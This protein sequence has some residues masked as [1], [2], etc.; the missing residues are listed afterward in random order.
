MAIIV[1][2]PGMLSTVQDLGRVGHR[3]LGINPGGVMDRTATRILNTLVGNPESAAVIEM[4]FPAATI[5]FDADTVFAVGGADFAPM[6]DDAP[7]ETWQ[8]KLASEGTVLSFSKKRFGERTYLAVKGG[9][10]TEPWLGSRS[11]NTVAGAGGF[12]GRAL[13]SGDRL[14]CLSSRSLVRL[15]AGVSIRPGYSRSPV[16]RVVAGPEFEFVTALS[17]QQFLEGQFALTASCDR[18]GY[19]LSGPPLSL[20][21]DFQLVSSGVNFGTVQLLPDGQLIVL[22]ADHQTSG[23]YPRIASVVEADLP[24]LAQCGPAAQISFEMIS[25]EA[26]ESL[27]LRLENELCFLKLGCRLQGDDDR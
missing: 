26:A 19:R 4:H 6:L 21:H 8:T 24:L 12:S 5:E 9:I 20:L 22:M 13:K 3:N 10:E 1:R 25:L 15:G 7:I 17:E 11:T 18:M 2:K 27:A 16:I 14:E 23:G